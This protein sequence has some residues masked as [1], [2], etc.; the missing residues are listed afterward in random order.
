MPVLRFPTLTR[1]SWFRTVA[2]RHSVGLLPYE[3]LR[4]AKFLT[5][6]DV[7]R[8]DGRILGR[9][10]SEGRAGGGMDLA[11]RYAEVEHLNPAT[12]WEDIKRLYRQGL[13]E[14]VQAPAPGKRAE[15]A[16]CLSADAVCGLPRGVVVP[17]DLAEALRMHQIPDSLPEPDQ[18]YWIG[19]VARA[20][21]QDPDSLRLEAA[22]VV[23][24]SAEQAAEL[25]AVRASWSPADLSAGGKPKAPR[26]PAAA[27]SHPGFACRPETSPYYARRS[28]PYDSVPHQGSHSRSAKPHGHTKTTPQRAAEPPLKPAER[29]AAAALLWA[30]RQS[31]KASAATAVLLSSKTW[32][33]D[34]QWVNDP[35]WTDLVWAVGRALRRTTRARVWEE[36]TVTVEVAQDLAPF[37]GSRLYRKIIDPLVPFGAAAYD[38][39]EPQVPRQRRAGTTAAAAAAQWAE[40]CPAGRDILAELAGRDRPVAP[41]PDVLAPAFEEWRPGLFEIEQAVARVM[42]AAGIEEPLSPAAAAER[43]HARALA[44]LRAERGTEPLADRTSRYLAGRG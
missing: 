39:E 3:A 38:G 27:A 1:R 12:F 32:D 13:A 21:A 42:A 40:D 19:G 25:A 14:R 34:G 15:Y 37:L 36:L 18:D 9:I 24:I 26:L 6:E 41:A 20:V 16:L 29:A 8:Y 4:V 35:A 10:D 44:R 11:E 22:D 31:W 7:C 33:D 17:S 30:A 43:T 5:R 23:E 2:W 28:L